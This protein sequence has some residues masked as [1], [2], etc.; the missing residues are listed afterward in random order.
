MC[1][2][3]KGLQFREEKVE[4]FCSRAF[5]CGS[6]VQNWRLRYVRAISWF[7]ALVLGPLTGWLAA[8]MIMDQQFKIVFWFTL[9][10][11]IVSMLATAFSSSR[12][13][14]RLWLLMGLLWLG[15]G[16]HK[17]SKREFGDDVENFF[18]F[19]MA[20]SIV[21]GVMVFVPLLSTDPVFSCCNKK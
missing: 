9:M 2:L 11:F 5:G 12:I 1:G 20:T 16:W 21:W 3:E 14:T 4:G 18:N 10:Y 17:Y 19:L 8:S 13:A 6:D 15:S 7:W